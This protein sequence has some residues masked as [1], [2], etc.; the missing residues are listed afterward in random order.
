MG[1]NFIYGF[2][3][4][5]LVLCISLLRLRQRKRYEKNGVKVQGLVSDLLLEYQGSTRA[6]YPVV[7]YRTLED[8]KFEEKSSFGTYPA[9]FK[10]GQKIDVIYD[11]DD[12]K[13]FIINHKK[14]VY[15]EV[16]FIVIGVLGLIIS[17]F[18][19]MK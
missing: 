2:I 5:L 6:Y 1:N 8:I 13:K 9:A 18:Y 12:H 4:S 11:R 10:K 14:Y 16:V 15:L 19:L 17:S 7:A 3:A